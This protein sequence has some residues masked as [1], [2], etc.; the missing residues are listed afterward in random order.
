LYVLGRFNVAPY[1]HGSVGVT[2]G[3]GASV[4]DGVVDVV[5]AASFLA[6]NIAR[7]FSCSNLA[8]MTFAFA[9]DCAHNIMTTTLNAR[10]AYREH[11]GVWSLGCLEMIVHVDGR[12]EYANTMTTQLQSRGLNRSHPTKI[13]DYV[14]SFS[15]PFAKA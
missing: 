13:G 5:V 6:A 14:A 12:F 1:V 11:Y 4:G 9:R 10:L 2:A 7:A 8:C 3:V 15:L